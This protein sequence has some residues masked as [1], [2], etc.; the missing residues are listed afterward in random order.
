MKTVYDI[1]VE[2]YTTIQK[3]SEN[4]QSVEHGIAA[5]LNSI[6]LLEDSSDEKSNSR[7]AQRELARFKVMP[8]DTFIT[9]FEN[10][11][12]RD[13]IN[14]IKRDCKL[15]AINRAL[16]SKTIDQETYKKKIDELYKHATT[17]ATD[18][19]YKGWLDEIIKDITD[20]LKFAV[21]SLDVMPDSVTESLEYI[22]E[23]E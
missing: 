7:I 22:P 13:Q 2:Y 14:Q 18:K 19:R 1:F 10:F 9:F 16:T 3:S 5:Y 17:F 20:C 15:M 12:L 21:G 8:L 11:E 4:T 6:G 23:E